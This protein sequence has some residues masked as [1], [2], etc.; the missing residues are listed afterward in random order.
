MHI[1]KMKFGHKPRRVGNRKIEK[2]DAHG[3]RSE[4]YVERILGYKIR[5]RQ[6]MRATIAQL[7]E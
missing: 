1:R 6:K 3:W 5:K 2:R 4:G 7:E